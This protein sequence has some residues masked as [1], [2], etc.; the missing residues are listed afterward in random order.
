MFWL[1]HLYFPIECPFTDRLVFAYDLTYVYYPMLPLNGHLTCVDGS[2]P[3]TEKAG[4]C[5]RECPLSHSWHVISILIREI[6]EMISHASD[7]CAANKK[8]LPPILYSSHQTVKTVSVSAIARWPLRFLLLYLGGLQPLLG[9]W[10]HDHVHYWRR[11]LGGC[12]KT[13]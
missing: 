9:F 3:A 7:F 8:R 12:S 1:F 5:K 6:F 11:L 2:E 4:Y 10:K 13:E